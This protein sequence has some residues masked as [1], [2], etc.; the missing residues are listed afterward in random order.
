MDLVS[1]LSRDAFLRSFRRFT[2]R[3]SV[4]DQVVSDNGTNFVS[5]S[6]VLITEYPKLVFKF[7]PPAAPHFGGVH[8]VMVKLMKKA[9]V[10]TLGTYRPTDEELLTVLAEIE[11]TLNTRPLTRLSSDPNDLQPLTPNHFL[12]GKVE[13]A[14]ALNET[15]LGAR[16]KTIQ[17]II[18]QTWD[19][20]F[21]EF[22]PKLNYTPEWDEPKHPINKL[23]RATGLW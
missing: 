22:I 16:W 8:E 20:F 6:K 23:E 15:P 10:K 7:I 11:E 13:L 12:I 1:D 19:R 4:P 3:N 21:R 2:A 14:A 9:L 17:E 18:K 5:A